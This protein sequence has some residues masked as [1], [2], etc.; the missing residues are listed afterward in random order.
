MNLKEAYS[1]LGLSNQATEEEVKKKYK[2]LT[3]KYHP[4]VN[5]EP[6][7]D[8]KFKKINEAYT[9]IK[10]GDEPE[11]DSL[12][13][14]F[15]GFNPFGG[16]VKAVPQHISIQT[17]ISF[18]ESVLGTKK[19]IS[20]SRKTKCNSCDGDGLIKLNNGCDKCKGRGQI[21]VSRGQMIFVQTC[22]KCMGKTKTEKCSPCKGEGSL[23][24]ECNI[25]V[26]VPGGVSDGNILRLAGMG[27][28]VGQFMGLDQSS[29]VHLYIHVEN[30]T[31]LSL[32]GSD[33]IS[34]LKISLLEALQGCAKVVPTVLDEKEINIKP[35]S[36]N[37]DVVIIPNLGVN[38]KGNQKV[39]LE[40]EYPQ[41]TDQIINLL[42]NKDA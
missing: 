1:T 7:A 10:E 11:P 40:V 35:L 31:N 24:S 5:K 32:E 18:Q 41:N 22:D 37:K 2:E 19:N 30:N 33:V 4:D 23:D 20:Y 15:S 21:T 29:D 14:G 3:R 8:A 16:R 26:S 42:Q 27:N 6:D 9:R 36:K 25:H 12:F 38:K 28:Y 17:T 34:Y 13:S 39:Y